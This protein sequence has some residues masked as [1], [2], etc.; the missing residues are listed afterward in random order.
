MVWR[1]LNWGCT[2][3][4][5]VRSLEAFSRP[6]FS[7]AS[8]LGRQLKDLE[9]IHYP[10]DAAAE[11]QELAN[12]LKSR[13]PVTTEL[14]WLYFLCSANEARVPLAKRAWLPLRQPN[15]VK[16]MKRMSREQGKWAI[17]IRVSWF[18]SPSVW[19]KNVPRRADKPSDMTTGMAIAPLQHLLPDLQTPEVP[20]APR[21]GS[22][23]GGGPRDTEKHQGRKA[24]FQ[25]RLG[26]FPGLRVAG[27]AHPAC[28]RGHETGNISVVSP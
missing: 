25:G 28:W 20:Y 4:E 19:L 26:V 27:C 13:Q 11:A 3:D 22:R 9:T 8:V 1:N 16:V 7:L 17:I 6:N 24:V 5:V 21:Q 2:E 18:L 15:D 10:E 14:S 23:Q 12:K